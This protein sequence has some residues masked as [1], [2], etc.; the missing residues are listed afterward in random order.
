[1]KVLIIGP[2]KEPITGVSV[3]NDLI[4]KK[5]NTDFINTS[6]PFFEEN[7]GRFSLNKIFLNISFYLRSHKI[8]RTDILYV[9]PGQSFFGVV[10]Y[11]PYILL[12][13]IL[14][15]QI[16]LHLHGNALLKTYSLLRGFKKNIFEYT[17]KK[18]SKGIVLS[19]SLKKNLIP[20]LLPENIFSIS[21]FVES[22]FVL[23]HEEL[24]DKP[25]N[26][27]NILYLSNLMTEKGIFVFLKAISNLR[28]K[29]VDYKC[30]LGGDI[31]DSIRDK[32]LKEIEKDESM[33]YMG[34]VRNKEKRALLKWGKVF[35]FPS[36]QT[37][38]LPI[39][40]L[41][42]MGAG[43]HVISTRQDALLDLFSEHQI[44]YVN[45]QSPEEI[46]N[47]IISN[48]FDDCRVFENHSLISEKFTET[49]FV[50]QILN[51]FKKN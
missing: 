28:S 20:F 35:V 5:L 16:V 51:V 45:K 25:K 46:S 22:K 34:V 1:M 11:L 48:S 17:L 41:E 2:L 9:T 36:I 38:G 47:L 21:N 8:L 29:G 32:V 50:N 15:K 40:I 10:K 12:G 26:E 13:K 4:Q 3:S 44:S 31:D 39:S 24:E 33:E 14:K 42:A 49:E 37:E 23:S 43:N 18:C 19:K 27:L 7:V 6:L 30:K